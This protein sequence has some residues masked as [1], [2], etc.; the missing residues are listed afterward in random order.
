LYRVNH[1]ENIDKHYV[2]YAVTFRGD[3][4]KSFSG[5]AAVPIIK[6]SLFEQ[7]K[8]PLPPLHE[9]QKIAEI[10]STVDKRLELLRQ[11]R[12]R[13]ENIKNGLMSDLLTGRVRVRLEA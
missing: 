9:Q 1:R 11:R 2:Y 12:G 7:F 8:L 5:V 3:I 6:K 13:L 10:L 4:L